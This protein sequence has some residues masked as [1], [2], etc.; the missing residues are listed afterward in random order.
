MEALEGRLRRSIGTEHI[1]VRFRLETTRSVVL[2]ID[3]LL[4][5]SGERRTPAA[6]PLEPQRSP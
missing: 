6:A 4:A 1:L 2:F 3:A 5:E